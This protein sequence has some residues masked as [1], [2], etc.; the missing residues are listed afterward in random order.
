MPYILTNPLRTMNVEFL[1]TPTLING[2]RD[3]A[4]QNVDKD[5]LKAIQQIEAGLKEY[6]ENLGKFV[7]YDGKKV[8]IDT[9][10]LTP[11]SPQQI[12]SF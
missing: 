7:L 12:I 8:T 4:L 2:L 10:T 3:Y 1:S 6:K 9:I 11:K 5:S